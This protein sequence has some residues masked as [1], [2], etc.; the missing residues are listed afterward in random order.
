LEDEVHY[1]FACI[2]FW[3]AWLVSTA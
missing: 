1:P 2:A 3:F